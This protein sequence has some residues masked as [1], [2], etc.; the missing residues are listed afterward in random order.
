MGIKTIKNSIGT[1][2]K[3]NE[4]LQKMG[5]VSSEWIKHTGTHSQIICWD[6]CCK[7]GK[8]LFGAD[9]SRIKYVIM[10]PPRG[11]RACAVNLKLYYSVFLD[12]YGCVYWSEQ[13]MAYINRCISLNEKNM[14]K[15]IKHVAIV[16][17]YHKSADRPK[18]EILEGSFSWIR[19]ALTQSSALSSKN[20][21]CCSWNKQAGRCSCDGAL[22]PTRE[23][24]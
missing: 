22:Y 2:R 19:A 23:R 5:D 4:M 3:I 11:H 17:H 15:T 18:P 20:G 13:R 12:L 7:N 8:H 9:E 24:S 1:K 10:W 14:D 6:C 21:R 16:H